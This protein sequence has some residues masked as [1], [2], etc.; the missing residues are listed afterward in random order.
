MVT[1]LR[2]MFAA[3]FF[4]SV[5][6]MVDPRLA[7]QAWPQVLA[8]VAVV[9]G[10]QLL[11]VGVA[12]FLGGHG[13]RRSVQAGLA[14]GQ[15]GEFSF[16][17]AQ[18]GALAGVIDPTFVPAIVVV[19]IVTA[20]TTPLAIARADRI[21]ARID[22]ALPSR[23]HTV[24]SLYQS[25]LESLRAARTGRRV[26]GV[27]RFARLAL[28]DTV[29]LAAIVIGS[30]FARPLLTEA[31]TELGLGAISTSVL[32]GVATVI[33]CL[34]F[35]IGLLRCV[36]AIGFTLARAAL[37]QADSGRTDLALAPR[38][39]LVVVIQLAALM[40]LVLPL[41]ALTGPFLPPWLGAPVLLAILVV[42]AVVFWRRADDLVG[43]VRAG[44]EVV[45]ELLRASAGQ[46]DTFAAQHVE[47]TLPGL[48]EITP[49]VLPAGA[50][51]CG[52]TLAELDLRGKS[53]ATVLAI[54]RGGEA[55][56]VPSGNEPLCAGDVLALVGTHDAIE[57]ARALLRGD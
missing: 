3:V 34:P 47:K 56:T 14:L 9:I 42:V 32:L 37:P 43:H 46:Q 11:V 49:V 21:A 45:V 50:P 39:V 10:G 40:A 53:G 26:V 2:D 8:I 24:A 30:A 4:V 48:G 29:A 41:L 20:T 57:R 28:V 51:A 17:L 27:R 5:G 22:H 19:G 7:L 33:V 36:R 6:M 12:A 23:L 15:V 25:W 31:L 55:R 18:T 54:E 13:I 38:R 52:R 44:A 35:A 16:I 1:P